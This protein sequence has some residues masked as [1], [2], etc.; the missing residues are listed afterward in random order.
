MTL[1]FQLGNQ[2][3]K[4]QAEGAEETTGGLILHGAQVHV[5]LPTPPKSYYRH[6]WQSWSLTTWH[7]PDLH[8]PVQKP[9]ILHP[10]QT[11]PLYAR[12]PAPNGSWLGAV[13]FEDGK[14]L[15]LGAL[16]LEAHVGLHEQLHGWYE[17]K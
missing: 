15:L 16:G 6:G 10:L 1:T 2:E 5:Y 3:F 9:S 8:I 17:S 7:A 13:A 14:V 4:I 12:H 11:D